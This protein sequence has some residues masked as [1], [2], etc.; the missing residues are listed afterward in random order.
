[1]E[2]CRWHAATWLK[3]MHTWTI[4][5]KTQKSRR[6]LCTSYLFEIGKELGTILSQHIATLCST[7]LMENLLAYDSIITPQLDYQ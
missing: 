5:G 6:R 7:I 4:S 1:M 2:Q 3:V